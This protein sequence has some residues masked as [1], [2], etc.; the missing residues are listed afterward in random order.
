[1][2]ALKEFGIMIIA[3]IVFRIWGY[4][5]ILYTFIKHL[6]LWDYDINK[7]LAPIFRARSLAEDGMANARAGELMNDTL[8][9]KQITKYG[10]WHETISAKT[11]ENF[12]NKNLNK[13]GLAG[14][15]LLDKVLGKNHCIS[16]IK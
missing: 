13:S 14:R 3:I 5:G 1:M 7:Q 11:G 16:S 10:K 8:L 9:I 12:L 2:K 15:I 4:V 6:C